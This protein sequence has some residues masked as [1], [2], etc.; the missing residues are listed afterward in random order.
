M[1]RVQVM[2]PVYTNNVVIDGKRR[3]TAYLQLG[4]LCDY[5]G[6]DLELRVKLGQLQLLDVV[7]AEPDPDEDDEQ[8][9][10]QDDKQAAKPPVRKIGKPMSKPKK[11][12]HHKK[13]R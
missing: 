8:D 1:A 2:K 6:D 13:K 7:E 4:Q 9:N 11:R 12:S 3:D 10:K 5:E